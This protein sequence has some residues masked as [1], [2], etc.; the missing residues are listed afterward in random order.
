MLVPLVD[1]AC[2]E[3]GLFRRDG[4]VIQIIINRN[5]LEG[6]VDAATLEGAKQ[7]IARGPVA[8][9]IAIKQLGTNGGGFYNSN[10]PRA[11]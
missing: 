2:K 1:A 6:S 11:P 7:L 8:F 9:M 5:T 3:Q 4:D 10:S